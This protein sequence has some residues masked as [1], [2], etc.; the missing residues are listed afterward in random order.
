MVEDDGKPTDE[1]V[2]AG[3][4]DNKPVENTDKPTEESDKPLSLYDKTEAIVTRQEAANKKR[5]ELLEREEKLFANQRLAGTTGGNVVT[6]QVSPEK[7]KTNQAQE[8]FKDTALGDD[9]SKANKKN[10]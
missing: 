9:I 8:F 7:K 4:E 5:E 2:P 1:S 3:K 6:K 10:E